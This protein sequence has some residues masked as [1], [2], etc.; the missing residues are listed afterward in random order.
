MEAIWIE[1]NGD[2]DVLK[3][4]FDAPIPSSP[5]ENQVLIKTHYASVNFIDTYFR[6]GLYTAPKFPLILG[7]DGSGVVEAVGEKVTGIKP[8]DRVVFFSRQTYAEYVLTTDSNVAIVPD[9]VSLDSAVA[10]V[11]N[12]MTAHYLT[13]DCHN[14]NQNSTVLVH[15]A[16]GGTGQLIA[17]ICNIKGARK[18][19]G[20]V[21][22]DEKV[23]LAKQFGCTDVIVYTKENVD[24]RVRQIVPEGVRVV[25]DGVGK[26]TWESSFR[27]CGRRADV[28]FF[29]NASG[30][31]PPVDPLLLTRY[32]SLRMTRPSLADFVTTREEFVNR[33][34]DLFTWMQEGKLK[35]NIHKTFDLSEIKQAHRE[36]ESRAAV[37]KIVIRVLKSLRK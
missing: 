11:V 15:A 18:I 29:G 14:V 3:H 9:G 26:S 25:F 23:A 36:I 27:S 12:G 24:E 10:C 37:G 35:V 8:G 34:S 30:P 5:T 4:V 31:V 20:T 21:G 16:A 28:V 33:A 13:H 7:Q 19:I 32:G 2:V 1:E 6:T 17:Q 22:S